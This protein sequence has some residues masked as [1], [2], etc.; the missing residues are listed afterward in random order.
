VKAFEPGPLA[1]VSIADDGRTVV[2]VRHFRHPVEKV[3][4]ALTDPGHL[5]QW[6]PFE[7]SRDL[8]TAGEATLTMIDADVSE[9]MAST[10][11]RAEAPTLLE[12]TWGEDQLRWELVA[13][14]E[15]TRLTLRH[16]VSEADWA[17]KVTAGWHLCLVVAEHLLDG[18]PIG[19]IRGSDALNYGWESL[20]D[21]Y[22]ARFGR[23]VTR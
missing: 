16:T 2:F 17:P 10:I 23:P 1:D 13:T 15:G 4:T 3:W 9:P 5:A 21:A 18:A 6:A 8:G 22:A 14:D 12:Y 19:V 20:R 11:L 7:A